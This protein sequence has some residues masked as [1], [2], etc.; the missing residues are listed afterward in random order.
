[1]FKALSQA[2]DREVLAGRPAQGK[3]I[4]EVIDR[5]L[6]N[7]RSVIGERLSRNRAAIDKLLRELESG[8]RRE[9]A[10]FDGGDPC[11]ELRLALWRGGPQPPW[12]VVA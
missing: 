3:A 7:K 2:R 1:V 10:A 11:R 9:G 5:V 8:P 6:A 4:G 12:P